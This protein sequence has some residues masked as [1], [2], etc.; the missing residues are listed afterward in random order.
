MD[1]YS[2]FTNTYFDHQEAWDLF[3]VRL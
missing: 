3:T 1:I 2:S